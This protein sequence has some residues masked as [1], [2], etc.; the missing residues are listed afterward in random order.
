MLPFAKLGQLLF[1]RPLGR[2]AGFAALGPDEAV[3]VRANL[4]RDLWHA[5]LAGIFGG[6]IGGYLAVVGRRMG[7]S[8]LLLA[9][10]LA[11]PYIGSLP[12]IF[13]PYLFGTEQ[14]ARRIAIAWGFGRLAWVATPFIAAPVQYAAMTLVYHF[15]VVIPEPAYTWLMQGAYP[16]R[17][18]GR[19]LGLGRSLLSLAALVATMAAGLLIDAVGHRPVLAAAGVV[20][21]LGAFA[22]GGMRILKPRPRAPLPLGS[23]VR[24][25]LSNRAFRQFVLAF[26]VMAA[27]GLV[28]APAMPI[29]LVDR[30]DASFTAVGVLSLL[31]GLVA[32]VSFVVWGR[33]IDRWTGPAASAVSTLTYAISPLVFML[34]ILAGHLWILLLAYA[35]MGFAG[36]GIGLGWQTSLMSMAPPEKTAPLATMFTTSIGLFGSAGPFLGGF[37]LL[38]WGPLAAFG[39][40]CTLMLLGGGLMLRMAHGFQPA[41]AEGQTGSP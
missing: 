22:F 36:A 15:L 24:E 27:G 2:L 32:T 40:A 26:N 14:P 4:T 25:A 31:S 6:V 33:I 41:I 39:L 35:A 16:A 20:G 1:G 17:L 38:A 23:L 21:A 9:L 28:M 8:E 34:A 30:F 7:A 37:V 11:G 10:M 12:A 3:L 29:V 18:R 13:A 5:L 19:L